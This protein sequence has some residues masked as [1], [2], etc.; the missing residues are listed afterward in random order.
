MVGSINF[1]TLVKTVAGQAVE[2][3]AQSC[4]FQRT[5]F[6]NHSLIEVLLR[7]VY[8]CYKAL[9]NKWTDEIEIKNY[10]AKLLKPSNFHQ[11]WIPI[12]APGVVEKK[13]GNDVVTVD[14]IWMLSK[15]KK[16]IFIMSKFWNQCINKYK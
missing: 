16:S 4:L 6:S 5:E 15:N 1:T 11:N 13:L 3:A 14:K 10:D 2:N 9:G 8:L 7:N 12:K